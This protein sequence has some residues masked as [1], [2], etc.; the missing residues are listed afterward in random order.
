MSRAGLV[1]WAA[2]VC[3]DDFQPGITWGEPAQLIADAMNQG[4]RSELDFGAGR[5]AS[6]PG[7]PGKRDYMD[8][9]Q[10]G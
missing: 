2:S 4:D 10:P 9:S 6:E 8:K 5:R 3:R 1:S 7:W